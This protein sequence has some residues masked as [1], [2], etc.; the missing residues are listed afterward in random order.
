MDV[1]SNPGKETYVFCVFFVVVFVCVFLMY[2]A[3]VKKLVSSFFRR[4]AGCICCPR[5]VFNLH[6]FVNREDSLMS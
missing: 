4:V 6:L 3:Y 5:V 1:G 2:H